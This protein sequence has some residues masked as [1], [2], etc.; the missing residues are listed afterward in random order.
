[1]PS[2]DYQIVFRGRVAPG[3]APEQARENLAKLFK[4]Q[5]EQ[6]EKLFDGRRQVLKK[7][8]ERE[9]ADR[10]RAALRKAGLIVSVVS[11]ETERSAQARVTPPPED[12]PSTPPAPAESEPSPGR[13]SF[14][15]DDPAESVSSGKAVFQVD[16]SPDEAREAEAADNAGVAEPAEPHGEDTAAGAGDQPAAAELAPVGVQLVA[17]EVIEPLTFDLADIELAEA[18]EVVDETA[19]P[20][21][22]EVDTSGLSAS[23]AFDALD[24]HEA[25]AAPEIDL[26]GFDV[27]SDEGPADSAEP[28]A[29]PEID[30]SGL[31]VTEEFD[32]LDP[33]QREP[34]PSIDTSHLELL[35]G[36]ESDA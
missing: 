17:P 29:A 21:P 7:G 24:E 14:A 25:P 30:T 10:Y 18:G 35:P 11:A 3:T 31:S 15:I 5:P 36:P 33:D 27:A 26:S 6:V 28:P 19:P 1:M 2:R 12:P 8:L 13:A 16:D 34:T 20:P 9:A 4:A 23:E 32:S 22:L